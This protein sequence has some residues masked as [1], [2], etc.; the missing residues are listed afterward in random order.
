MQEGQLFIVVNLEGAS[1]GMEEADPRIPPRQPKPHTHV[2]HAGYMQ[3]RHG[4]AAGDAY[5]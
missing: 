2:E 5:G 1:W 4:I 3:G